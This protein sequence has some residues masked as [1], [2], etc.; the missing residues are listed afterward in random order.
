VSP[1]TGYYPLLSLR[2][3]VREEFTEQVFSVGIFA[4]SLEM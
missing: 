4:F 3:S 2:S 1:T